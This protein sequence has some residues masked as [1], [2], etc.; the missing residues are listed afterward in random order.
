MCALPV[1]GAVAS[2]EYVEFV[3]MVHEYPAILYKLLQVHTAIA[4]VIH[5]IGAGGVIDAV[6][7]DWERLTYLDEEGG[8]A[9]LLAQ[10]LNLV[11][12]R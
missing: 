5:M 6:L 2:R 3:H 9:E 7:R 1:I 10:R 8:D 12:A 11:M 4:E